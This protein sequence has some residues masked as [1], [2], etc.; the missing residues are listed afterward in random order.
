MLDD[1][2]QI[3]AAIG[4]KLDVIM[5][6]KVEGAW[7][8]HYLDQFLAQLEAKH[9]VKKP[10][11]IHAILKTAEG[12]DDVAADIAYAPRPRMHGMAFIVADLAASRAMKTTRVGGGH[13]EYKVLADA[14]PGAPGRGIGEHFIFGMAA[15][16]PRRLHR[17]R[18]RAVGG[19]R[20]CAWACAA[21][22]TGD[23]RRRYCTPFGGLEDR[24]DEDRFFD[25]VLGFELRQKL[26]EIVD[27]PGAFDL[28]RHDDV[29]L[30]P[31]GGDD[32]GD[33]V[34]RWIGSSDCA[35]RSDRPPGLPPKLARCSLLLCLTQGPLGVARAPTRSGSGTPQLS[36]W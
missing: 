32:L 17:P 9:G 2:T 26:I 24:V 19:S 6:P 30:L 4:Q 28:R 16:D 35:H 3:V 8:I 13:P 31:D 36:Q 5:L 29:E 7:D 21:R 27:V 10:I 15:A 22:G 23:G 20:G 33:V 1:I 18:E 14:T 12:V 34:E 11:L 25:A